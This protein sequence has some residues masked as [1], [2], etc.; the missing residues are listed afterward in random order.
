MNE[1]QR[2]RRLGH[3]VVPRRLERGRPNKLHYPKPRG[4]ASPQSRYAVQSP[5][6]PFGRCGRNG[7]GRFPWSNIDKAQYSSIGED[8]QAVGK[9]KPPIE[10]GLEECDQPLARFQLSIQ[11]VAPNWRCGGGIDFASSTGHELAAPCLN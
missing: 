7:T 4:F 9:L 5:G 8:D 6:S 10:I 1:R 11:L 2:A 3:R